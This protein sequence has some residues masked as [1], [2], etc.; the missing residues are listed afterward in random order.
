MLVSAGVVAIK[1]GQQ[2][3]EDPDVKLRFRQ[4][5]GSLRDRNAELAPAAFWRLVPQAERA[6]YSELGPRLGTGSIKQVNRLRRTDGVEEVGAVLNPNVAADIDATM[7]ALGVLPDTRHLVNQLKPM[8]AREIDFTQEAKSFDVLR[9]TPIGRSANVNIPTVR[10]ALPTFLARSE[11]L[12]ESVAEL[13]RQGELTKAQRQALYE[14]HVGLVRAA[15]ETDT[16]RPGAA[17]I[18]QPEAR[19]YILTDPH[20]GNVAL[21]QS[22]VG[23]FDP[24]Q[25]ET[26]SHTEAD[27]FVSML[28]SFRKPSL[29][30]RQRTSL[31]SRL[32]QL[33]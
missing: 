13:S 24:G 21:D 12:G 23:L 16:R 33:S 30:E 1:A 8:M 10:V 6:N 32:T 22:R 2:M 19:T 15:L 20:E 3:S 31:V 7:G 4:V 14:L 25:Y 5:L 18:K 9:A 28:G 17:V 26:L 27:F 29:N 11:A